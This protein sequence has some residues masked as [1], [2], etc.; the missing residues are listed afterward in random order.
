MRRPIIGINCNYVTAEGSWFY[1]L[2]E[3]YARGVLMAGGIPFFLPHV[4]T[5]AEIGPML[6][7]I[8]GLLLTGGADID[9]KRW[10]DRLHPKAK[11][12]PSVKERADFALVTVALRRKTPILAIC[13]GHQLVNVIRGGSLHQHIP[14]LG[15]TMLAH[16]NGKG[17]QMHEVRI[18][19]GTRVHDIM[20]AQKVEVC[21]SHH[22]SIDRPGKGVE[23][24]SF[25]RDGI[26]ESME[27]ANGGWVIG[28][29][30]HPERT[31][32][33]RPHRRLFEAL[34]DE[35]RRQR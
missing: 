7:R 33:A 4:A 15:E 22:Q 21:S 1:R 28:V 34:V 35:S 18:V 12:L 2:D 26:V 8:D 23:I 31:L 14:D 29:Q 17:T 16:T 9:A 19:K 10:G 27:G 11:L 25:A 5:A 13:Y 24:S 32:G 6:E 3:R 30:W 20:G